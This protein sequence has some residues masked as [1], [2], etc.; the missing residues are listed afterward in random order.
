LSYD[1]FFE[2]KTIVSA[3]ISDCLDDR[4]DPKTTALVVDIDG[5]V[6]ACQADNFA[7]SV[8]DFVLNCMVTELTL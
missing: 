2:G 1:P 6:Y 3:A 5:K 4:Q 7:G 8:L